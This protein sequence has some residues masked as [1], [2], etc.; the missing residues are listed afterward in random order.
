MYKHTRPLFLITETPLHAGSGSDLGVVDLPI[1]RERH[2]NYPKVEASSLKGS[3][4]QYFEAV[5]PWHLEEDI[6][7]KNTDYV[8]IHR[9]F[10]FDDGSL[11]DD[12][13][14][15]LKELFRKGDKDLSQYS[16]C[17]ALSDARILLFPVKSLHGVFTWVTCPAVLSRF[18]E[19][20]KLCGCE[21]F[22]IGKLPNGNT[23]PVVSNAKTLA[24]KDKIQ[25]EEY[26]FD[27]AENSNQPKVKCDSLEEELGN[28]LSRIIFGEQANSYWSEKMK[29]DVVI[30]SNDNFRDFVTLST[31]VITRTKINNNTGT[32]EDGALFTEEYLPMESVMYSLSMFADEFTSENNR[33]KAIAEEGQD[34]EGVFE[35][36]KKGLTQNKN[37]IQ[38]GANATL[39]KGMIRTCLAE[40]IQPKT[41]KKND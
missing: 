26:V 41:T 5:F 35:F 3:L 1:Q 40:N 17:L 25:L 20:M 19:D 31:E 13:K 27:I 4:R 29:T 24:P 6:K 37:R 2:T 34:E 14:K 30:L 36:F 33:L 12:N 22:S 9:T 11:S 15:Q 32:V 7:D 16:G 18:E 39:G 10:G 28:Y 21:N 8:K 23:D 38:L